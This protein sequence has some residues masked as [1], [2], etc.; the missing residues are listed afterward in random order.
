MG[1]EG[2]RVAE[3]EIILTEGDRF[4]VRLED[5]TMGTM[6]LPEDPSQRSQL[7][8]GFRAR[9]QVEPCDPNAQ[10]MV[11]LLSAA[12]SG[13]PAD[14]FDQDVHRLHSVLTNHRIPPNGWNAPDDP[15]GEKQIEAWVSRVGEA[16][17]RI[18]KNRTK[19]LDE[20]F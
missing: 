6:L 20:Q 7:T 13:M 4:V 3:G 1:P 14:R 12:P 11:V 16:L 5:G 17:S 2:R 8:V 18:R 10:P 15:A 19:R 9:F